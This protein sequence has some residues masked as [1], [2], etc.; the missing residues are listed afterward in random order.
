MKIQNKLIA[1][2]VAF[3]S[4]IIYVL[5]LSN[6]V[7]FWDSGEFIACADSL[8]INHAPGNP[9]YLLLAR[10]FAIFAFNPQNTALAVNLFSAFAAAFAVFFTSKTIFWLSQNLL[11]KYN[12]K[13]NNKP[14]KYKEIISNF[15]SI[16]G[17]LTLAF[18]PSFWAISTEAE[19]YS[20]SLCFT[21]LTIWLMIKFVSEENEKAN[22]WII[23]IALITGLA[24]GVHLLNIL[25]IPALVFLYYFKKYKFSY[26][27]FTI[28]FFIALCLLIFT[29]FF[30]SGFPQIAAYFEKFFVNSLNFPLYSGLITFVILFI[31]LLILGIYF[32]GKK[33]KKLLN[34]I[35]TSV[36]VFF[37]AYLTYSTLII[38]SASNPGIDQNN[39]ENIY[40]FISYLNREQY[41]ERPL[42][43]GQQFSSKLNKTKPYKKGEA[44]Y[45]INNGKYCLIHNKPKA[46]YEKSDIRT[47]PRMWSSE[48]LHI[49]GYLEWTKANKTKI[50]SASQNFE[51]MFRYQFGHLYLRYFMWNFVGKQ[52]NYQSHGS[53]ISGNWISGFNFIDKIRLGEQNSKPKFLESGQA[54]YYFLPLIL[55]LI[56]IIVQFKFDKKNLFVIFLIFIFTG[57][58]ISFYLN[59]TPYQV[60]ERDYAFLGSFY[61]FSLWIGLGFCGLTIFLNKFVKNK[62]TIIV[63]GLFAVLISPAQILY[64]NYKIQNKSQDD[65][66]YYF[67]LNLLNTCDKNAILF[68]SG[69]N[70]TYPLWYL[71]ECENI[72]TDVKVINL[73]FLNNDWHIDQIQKATKGSKG[74]NIELNRE[75]YISGKSDILP[76]IDNTSKYYSFI[77]LKNH[78]KIDN[79][80][81]EIHEEFCGILKTSGYA[82]N[83]KK[84]FD[85]FEEYFRN[86]IAFGNNKNFKDYCSIIYNLDDSDI[87]KYYGINSSQAENIIKK[88]EDLLYSHL[89]F[90]SNLSSKL[91]FMFSED[92]SLMIQSKLYDYPSNY[93]PGFQF[94]MPI[95]KAEA[96]KNFEKAGLR[97]ELLVD[98]VIWQIDS[99]QTAL[100]KSQLIAYKIIEDNNWE[101]PIYF[102]SLMDKESYFGLES[103]LYL[104]G[105][106]FRLFPI[107]TEFTS[108]DLVNVNSAKMY[109]NFINKFRWGKLKYI[110]Q[111]IENLLIILRT[112]YSKLSRALFLAQAYDASE[113]SISHCLKLIPNKKLEFE[114]SNVGL[115][116]GYYRLRKYTEASFLSLAIANNMEKEI[117]FYNQLPENLRISLA[118]N[119]L[120]AQK[121]IEELLVLAKDYQNTETYEKLKNIYS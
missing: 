83:Y 51:F 43:K 96:I 28:T 113:Y 12:L 114:Y 20:L 23:L 118:Q 7:N 77:Y 25:I 52:N 27:N 64:K 58:A 30:I 56:G 76:I 65:F 24:I 68:V 105:L 4:F 18:I 102:S 45:D 16:T 57:I 32:S 3:F 80:F 67:A 86:I 87:Q 120:K 1:P 62:Y 49:Q 107:E 66:A 40:N 75:K 103:Y 82:K 9:T 21:S 93:C 61:A 121:T 94:S 8:Q 59:Q 98:E 11:E 73:S 119:Y 19:V 53:V 29:Q 10:I 91:E 71:Q 79:S 115:V 106:A 85:S 22:R 17:S 6:Y 101:R 48:P 42:W 97:E 44:I 99:A 90:T 109:D 2:S 117:N 50:P 112:H 46:N 100:N 81:L 111:D 26:K 34:L 110:D 41:G 54:A 84:E 69:D 33:N 15:A 55:G 78:E 72:R 5:T 92:T 38:R 63:L 35:F 31:V 70:E 95:N 60:R 116:H 88:I 47:F 89:L 39:N 37:T 104:E 13:N 36:F 14:I 108:N 74:V